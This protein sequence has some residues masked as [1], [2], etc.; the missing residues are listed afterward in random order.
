AIVPPATSL[1]SRQKVLQEKRIRVRYGEVEENQI[2]INPQL[3]S[4]L[5]ITDTAVL[6]VAGKKRFTMNVIIDEDVPMDIVIANPQLMKDN[7]VADNSIAT[8]RKS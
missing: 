2:K 3:A 6:V 7:G 1:F 8:I 4:Q 5:G